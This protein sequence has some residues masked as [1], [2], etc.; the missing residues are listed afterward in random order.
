MY[1]FSDRPPRSIFNLIWHLEDGLLA[2][3]TDA[4]NLV[5]VSC[6]LF[7]GGEFDNGGHDLIPFLEVRFKVG[8][9]R[10]ACRL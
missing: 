6:A 10:N 5:N 9:V 4:E 1:L 8:C 2:S 3:E 7:G